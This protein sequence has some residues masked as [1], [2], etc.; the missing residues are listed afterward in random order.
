MVPASCEVFHKA[1]GKEDMFSTK[2][3]LYPRLIYTAAHPEA[4]L[5]A[6]DIHLDHVHHTVFLG[7]DLIPEQKQLQ[8]C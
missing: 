2:A 5:P 6:A 1:Q 4:G 7:D 8:P 3:T